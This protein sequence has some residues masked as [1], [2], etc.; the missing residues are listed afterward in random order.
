[1]SVAGFLSPLVVYAIV[2][3]LH[4]LLPAWKV[5]G[6]VTDLKTGQPLRYRLNGLLVYAFTVGLWAAVCSAGWLPWD[7][8]WTTRWEGLAGAC[9]LGLLFTAAVV[10]PAP[11]TGKPLLADL[12]LGRLENPQLEIR[13]WL[14]GRV[15]AKMWLY[16]VGA[17][18]LGLNLYSF[19]MHHRLLYP[20]APSFGVTLYVTL[21][22][23]FLCEYLFFERV[24]LYTYDFVAERVG[25]KLGWG[26][27]LF[28][29]YFYGVGLWSVAELP[30]PERSTLWHVAAAVVFFAGWSLARGANMQKFTFKRFPTTRFLGWIDPEVVTDGQ[31]QL[32]VSG[33]WRVS[34]HV[35]Y[36]G[37]ILMATGLT[38]ALGHPEVWT[39]WLYPAY[40]VALLFPR[41]RDDDR[42]CAAKYGPLWKTYCER[43][44][45]RIIPGIY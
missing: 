43:V 26:C 17:T 37:E 16:L 2:T 31:R 34:R 33:F 27:L 10:L 19:A 4:V 20:D 18:Q 11:P 36:L 13:P 28:Y 22:S 12:F 29:P 35:N 1:M 3:A 14:G 45:Y 9:V 41:E 25:F 5:D 38:L 42:R 44:P 6:Y 24:H 23:F 39:T 8:L 7:F 40:Y 32:L 30:S 21:F 15:D